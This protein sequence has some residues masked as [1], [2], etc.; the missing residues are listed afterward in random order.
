MRIR[1]ENT[2]KWRFIFDFI[3]L[4]S[5]LILWLFAWGFAEQIAGAK[6]GLWG[7]AILPFS[8]VIH[9]KW[10][11]SLYDQAS[12]FCFVRFT[13]KV[14]ISFSETKALVPFTENNFSQDPL[15]YIASMPVKERKNEF[16]KKVMD[17]GVI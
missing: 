6:I 17:E 16:F 7:L 1:L 14:P 10:L 2:H 9:A 15:M 13:L 4:A 3:N 11:H 8:W 12:A 5:P